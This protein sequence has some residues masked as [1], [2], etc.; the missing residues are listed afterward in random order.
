MTTESAQRQV[1]QA[2]TTMLKVMGGPGGLVTASLRLHVCS[3][4][5]DPCSQETKLGC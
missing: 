1:T 3:I 5:E 2:E 4:P